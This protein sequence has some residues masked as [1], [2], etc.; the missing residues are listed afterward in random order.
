MKVVDEHSAHRATSAPM[1]SRGGKLLT[2]NALDRI[3]RQRELLTIVPYSPMHIWR[4]EQ[5]GRFPLRIHLGP[6]RVGW[7]LRE[8][9]EWVEARKAERQGGKAV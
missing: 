7:S 8:V 4:L 5:A 1:Q 9:L 2:D 6:G 3:I